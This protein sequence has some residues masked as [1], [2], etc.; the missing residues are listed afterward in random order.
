MRE[1]EIWRYNR[2]MSE[3]IVREI[4][5]KQVWEDFLHEHAEAN[6]LQSWNWG[7]FYIKLGQKVFYRG[8]YSGEELVG[9]M[10]LIRE[11]AKRG[12]HLILPGG[13]IFEWYDQDLIAAFGEELRRLGREEKAVFIR[14]RPQLQDNEQSRKIFDDLGFIDAPMHLHAELTHRLDLSL[15]E[16]ELLAKMRK[17]TRYEIRKAEKEGI[18]VIG[19]QD[20]RQIREFY[21]LQLETAQRQKF[22]P[23]SLK[24]W[25]KQFEAFAPDNEVVLYSA[26]YEDKLL[27]QAMI[28]FYGQEAVY[29]YG[30]STEWAHKYPGAPAIQ[31]AA[32]KEAK[33]RGLSRYNF[34]GV[35]PEGEMQHRFAKL[36][37]FKR[38]FAGEDF[39][40]LHA[41]DLVIEPLAYQV[42]LLVERMRKKIRKV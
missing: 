7:Q 30:A 40:Y 41:Q 19:K 24:Y 2:L 1:R 34:W 14:C 5:E 6:F 36:S 9:V 42:N 3:I 15:S 26:Y 8:F 32:I 21:D 28:I 10:L 4:K 23:F 35:A 12:R 37:V 38:G 29:H 16:E 17:S 13:P 18:K 33:K 27:A 31:W 11:D 25:Q 22:V 20:E 39:A